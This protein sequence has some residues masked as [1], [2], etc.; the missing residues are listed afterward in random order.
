MKRF[1]TTWMTAAASAVLL[2][3]PATGA[4][5]TPPT[6]TPPTTAQPPA[7]PPAA[8]ATAQPEA[9]TTGD[10]AAAQEHLRKASASLAE[11]KTAALP[12]TAKTQVAEIKRRLTTLEKT[13]AA[14]ASP[15]AQAKNAKAADTW[16]T[17][18]AAIDK[19]LTTLLGPEATTGATPTG[20]SGTTPTARNKAAAAITLDAEAKASLT[21]VRTHLTAFAAA[22]AGGKT[23]DKTDP[24]TTAPAT[25]TAD[26][27]SSNP[28]STIPPETQPTDPPTA[29]PTEPTTAAPNTSTPAAQADQEKARRHLTEGRNTLSALTQLPAAAQLTGDARTQVAQLIANFNELIT[30]QSQWRESFA[31]VSGNL[32]A[33]LGPE[34]AATDPI[35]TSGTAGAVGT[36]GTTPTTLDPA[37]REKLVELHTHLSAF[38]KAAG[39]GAAV[40]TT[41]ATAGTAADTKPPASTSPTTTPATSAPTTP[42]TDPATAS[43]ASPA[44]EPAQQGTTG[45]PNTDLARHVAAIEGLL[46]MQDDSGGLTLTKAQ[47]EQLRTHWAALR[48]AID[49]K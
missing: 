18:V 6:S 14:K 40:A 11:V 26:P 10:H 36:S 35:S 20:T 42:A 23:D 21:E 46:K 13:T 16:G 32:T 28:T 33:L 47:V 3:L 9:T 45:A 30:T 5:Q 27:A 34:P 2:T 38:E 31:K 1:T 41:P 4:A 15:T 12:A 44:N 43:P 22:M 29:Q 25:A 49:K 48:A 19:A 37:I 8:G 24:A 7:T 39:G 17:E